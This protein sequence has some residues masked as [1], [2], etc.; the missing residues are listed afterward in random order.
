VPGDTVTVTGVHCGESH[1]VDVYFAGTW[2]EEVRTNSVGRFEVTITI[3]ESPRGKHEV[4]VITKISNEVY[5][6]RC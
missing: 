2:I 5:E 1:W 6:A 3:P 4:L